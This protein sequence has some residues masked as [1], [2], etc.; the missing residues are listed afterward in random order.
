MRVS[1]YVKAGLRNFVEE[2]PEGSVGE[3]KEGCHRIRVFVEKKGDRISDCKFNATKR[4][5]KLLA[6]ADYMCE[7]VKE[8]GAIP[9]KE[10]LLSY[11]SE[12]KERDKMENRA[13]IALS[14]LKQA[15][16]S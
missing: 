10:E 3:C 15:L 5:K 13:D 9:S 4:C 1:D 12:E 11:F 14:A 8:R 2:L 16:S 6:I 7:L